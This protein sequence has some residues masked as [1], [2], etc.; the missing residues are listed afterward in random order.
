MNFI[1]ILFSLLNK[2]IIEIYIIKIQFFFYFFISHF[3]IRTS[4]SRI[5]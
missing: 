3:L 2:W 4:V 5:I 1:I